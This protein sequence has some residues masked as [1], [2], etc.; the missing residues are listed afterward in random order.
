[1][2]RPR[3][4][5]LL[6]DVRHRRLTTVVAPAGF[7]KST[8]LAGWAAERR[9]AWYTCTEEDA[10]LDAFVAGVVSALRIRVT[11]IGEAMRDTTRLSRERGPDS[12]G[13]DQGRAAA[14]AA[15]LALLLEDLLSSELVLVIDDLH[16]L[17]PGCASARFTEALI[18]QAPPSLHLVVLSRQELPF[19]TARLR[20]RG[21]ATEIRGSTLAFDLDETL[22]LASLVDGDVG[23]V[24]ATAL[25]ETTLGWPAAVRLGAE[26]GRERGRQP[27]SYPGDDDPERLI[28][29]FAT[30]VFD[31]IEPELAE[32]VRQVAP[33]EVFTADLCTEIGLARPHALLDS[34]HRRGLI[35]THTSDDG[36]WYSLHPLVR[37]WARRNLAT[38]DGAAIRRRAADWLV[39][40]G[41]IREA[42][43]LLT[44]DD[45][46]PRR[47]EVLAEHGPRLII[48]GRADELLRHL[49]ALR[50]G[51]AGDDLLQLEGEARQATGD[52]DGALVC[53][54]ALTHDGVMPAGPAW[55]TGFI[56]HQRG[57]LAQALAA[58]DRSDR[59]GPPDRDHAMVDALSAAAHWLR[60]DVAAAEKL[61]G[62]ARRVADE[63]GDDRAL[64]AAHTALAMVAAVQGDRRTNDAHYLRALVHAERAADVL[65]L[66]RI[67][68]NRG[69]RYLEEGEYAEALAGLDTAIGLADLA[70][71]S[72]LRGIALSNRGQALLNLGQ[73]DEARRDL[74]TARAIFDAAGAHMVV[75][76][77]VHLGGIA[78][79]RDQRREARALFEEAIRL[80]EQS[81][82]RQALVPALCGLARVVHADS[83]DQAA[84][85]TQ[86]AIEAGPVLGHE[87]ALLTEAQLALE[88]GDLNT[89][90]ERAQEALPVARG[91]RNRAALTWAAEVLARV[92]DDPA[93]AR[94]LLTEAAESWAELDHRLDEAR[95]RLLIGALPEA[96]EV[97]IAGAA[98]AGD[99]LRTAGARRDLSVV[100]SPT[101]ATGAV[102]QALG[103]FA[104]NVG[105]RRIGPRDWG[106]RK[107]RDLLKILVSQRGPVRREQL[108]DLLWRDDD[109]A[110]A[111][112]KL[113]VALST[114]RAL[115]DPDHDHDA[116]HFVVADRAAVAL[117]REHWVIDLERFLA[118]ADEGLRM[119]ESGEPG[120]AARLARAEALMTGEPFDEDA[121]AD[122]A[123][124]VRD[125]VRAVSVQVL[126]ALA[127][128]AVADDDFD[129]AVRLQLRLLE[130]DAYD[131]RAHRS[132]VDALVAGGRHG[133]ARRM[134]RGYCE[135]MEELEIEPAPFPQRSRR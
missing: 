95:V 57:D 34:L 12:G 1:M 125:E 23:E 22:H 91:R 123:G 51:T 103:G 122:W 18:R 31:G 113:S 40:R 24:A 19:P 96:S 81:G 90:A 20:S 111:G 120:A 59:S 118:T 135:R 77:L 72:M 3:V 46:E 124:P 7:G 112:R 99:L 97:D 69:S 4:E 67:H 6:A 16:E 78:A 30:E 50:P 94:D 129:R 2:P 66:I 41:L 37:A 58:Y 126:R 102:V 10:D 9:C 36:G 32:L 75:Y 132:L 55:R 128:H 100:A 25:H 79:A 107:P 119:S 89:A 47:I 43:Q 101:S 130:Q 54:D 134:Y 116:D 92:H 62:E 115:L 8:L 133:E 83:P 49:T 117:R 127:D 93:E 5:S 61:A 73:L 114:L 109:P 86:R 65:Q 21:H 38:P 64:A 28:D 11:G 82:D 105:N 29:R 56:H 39:G 88:R 35:R 68:C 48:E 76:P 85:L 106:S 74:A 45:A 110:K 70:G 14:H 63:L 98:S 80:C 131:E 52:W 71:H 26:A 42:L 108:L 44:D 33:L 53:F 84:E 121:Y 15:H 87:T 27:D 60:G 17:P 104:V 13:G